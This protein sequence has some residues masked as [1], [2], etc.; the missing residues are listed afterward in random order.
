MAKISL[1]I[2][3]NRP[4]KTGDYKVLAQISANYK[5]TRVATDVSV[6]KNNWDPK[7]GQ[8]TK[9][10]PMYVS[11][12]A[13]L[14][15][16]KADADLKIL[17][18]PDKVNAMDIDQLK[19]YLLKGKEIEK[20]P[21]MPD[22]F[23]YA[24]RKMSE[25]H[26][27]KQG[28]SESLISSVIQKL[29]EYW[30][31]PRLEFNEM[32][33]VFLSQWQY[34]CLTTPK[35]PTISKPTSK[36][37]TYTEKP[38]T[39]G[40]VNV[41]FRYIRLVFNEALSD[42][43]AIKYPFKKFKLTTVKTKNRNLPV[44]TIRMIR[45]YIP[46]NYREEIT[47]DVLMLQM[48]LSGV[49]MADIW[50]FTK[51]NVVNGR[52]QFYRKKT[53]R[54]QK[55]FNIKIEPEAQAILDKHKGEKYLLWFADLSERSPKAKPHSRTSEFQYKDEETFLS[56]INRSLVPIQKALGIHPSIKI[57]DYYIRHSL[58]TIL[59][60]KVIVDGARIGVSDV[61]LIFGHKEVEHRVTGTYIDEDYYG[62]DKIMRA[63]IDLL[64]D[65]AKQTFDF[66]I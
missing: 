45:D 30:K 49:N 52:L 31:K 66:Q 8:V 34:W 23:I 48:Y 6:E 51:E 44:E 28:K 13:R 41:Y 25:Y 15:Q 3:P 39:Q 57:T 38:M 7:N 21:A 64:N 24:E 40:G 54:Y 55:F 11:K 35:R 63:L 50:S 58:A 56:M 32:T 22:F 36:N 26:S 10:D 46:A 20:K 5:T 33:P 27:M 61:A 1:I 16:I 9:G 4:L 17:Q 60:T 62:N 19:V 42:E 2:T 53:I 29:K 43:L 59:R 18:F 12:N 37:K 14:N 65:K 47:R